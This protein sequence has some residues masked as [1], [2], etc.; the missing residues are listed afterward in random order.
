[1]FA[2]ELGVLD[3]G[4]DFGLGLFVLGL[5]SRALDLGVGIWDCIF[6]MVFWMCDCGCGIGISDFEFRLLGCGFGT[7]GN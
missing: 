7:S 2:F 3:W 4:R 1:M 5:G 6:E